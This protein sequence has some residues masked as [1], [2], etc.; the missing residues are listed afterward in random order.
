M[1][2][3]INLWRWWFIKPHFLKPLIHFSTILFLRYQ[4]L[5]SRF[6]LMASLTLLSTPSF[7]RSVVPVQQFFVVAFTK[8]QN[9]KL[10]I[11]STRPVAII[12]FS[13]LGLSLSRLSTPLFSRSV[14]FVQQCLLVPSLGLEISSSVKIL[15][16]SL[17]LVTNIKR[18]Q[19]AGFAVQWTTQNPLPSVALGNAIYEPQAYGFRSQQH[20]HNPS[21]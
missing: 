20:N 19:P 13:S 7:N 2:C 16:C 15:I 1:M 5:Q 12:L 11:M 14:V 6:L 18:R 3:S 17:Y 21:P 4:L 8:P 9:I 10:T